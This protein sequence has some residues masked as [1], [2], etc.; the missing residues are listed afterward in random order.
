MDIYAH[1]PKVQNRMNE[2]ALLQGNRTRGEQGER[3]LMAATCFL[4]PY[5]E[6][7]KRPTTTLKAENCWCGCNAIIQ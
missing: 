4:F 2:K 6:S 7:V 1:R 5:L 3:K